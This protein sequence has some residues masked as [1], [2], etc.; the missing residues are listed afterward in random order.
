MIKNLKIGIRNS[1]IMKDFTKICDLLKEFKADE[2]K[3]ISREFQKYGYDLAEELGDLKNKSLYIKLAKETPRGLLESA[4]NFVKD[5]YN[6]K[7]KARLFMWK[8]SELK[9]AKLTHKGS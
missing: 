4:K 7:S 2:D 6:V 8:L 5:A 3:Y 1:N 9:R